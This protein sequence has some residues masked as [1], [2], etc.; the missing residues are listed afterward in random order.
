MAL[1]HALSHSPDPDPD[2][3]GLHLYQSFLRNSLAVILN[4]HMNLIGLSRNTDYGHF[5]TEWRWTFVRHSCT[6]RNMA[7]STSGASLSRSAGIF[8][9]IRRPLRSARPSTYQR[10]ADDS[11]FSSSIGGCRR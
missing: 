3:L 9:S 4:L 8:S 10:T 7:S 11:P 2:S 5:A 6:R 1:P